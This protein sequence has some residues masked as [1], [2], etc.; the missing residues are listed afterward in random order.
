MGNQTNLRILVVD[1]NADIRELLKSA[2]SLKGYEVTTISNPSEFPYINE[3]TCT[4]PE[5]H[6]C[7]DIIIADI[8]MPKIEGIDFLKQL[9]GAGC[10]PIKRGM[11][12]IMSGYLTIHYMN[13]LNSLGIHYFRKPFELSE[14]FAWVEGCREQ[15][16]A[17]P[18]AQ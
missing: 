3:R 11:A 6:P 7:T 2:L 13:E 10:W 5:G 9:K 14:V 16:E 15:F 4:C 8:V 1:D 12:A 18:T 17:A